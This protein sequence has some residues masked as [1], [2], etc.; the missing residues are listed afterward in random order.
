[1]L[2]LRSDSL[3]RTSETSRLRQNRRAD[4]F[5]GRDS[6]GASERRRKLEEREGQESV[7]LVDREII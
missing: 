7:G 1:M 5:E 3:L 2:P 4:D 6:G